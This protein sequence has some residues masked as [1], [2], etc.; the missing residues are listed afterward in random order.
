MLHSDTAAFDE[1]ALVRKK[2]HLGD[3][4]NSKSDFIKETAESILKNVPRPEQDRSLRRSSW[5]EQIAP[6]V[7]ARH[8][9]DAMTIGHAARIFQFMTVDHK[10][11]VARKFGSPPEAFEDW[12]YRFQEVRNIAAHHSRLWN[13]KFQTA[14]TVPGFVHPEFRSK[15]AVGS[16]I[17]FYSTAVVMFYC[18]QKVAR[19]TSWHWGL[20]AL[21]DSKSLTPDSIDVRRAMGFPTSWDKSQFWRGANARKP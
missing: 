9:V 6:K 12:L 10:R 5:L 4:I 13:I 14:L 20:H 8:A 2:E 7:D 21:L 16:Q 19:R 11:Q 3:R 18:L 15:L 1:S 17:R